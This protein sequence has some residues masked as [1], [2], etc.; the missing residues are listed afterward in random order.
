MA[1]TSEL[2][3]LIVRNI[4]DVEAALIRGRELGHSLI[5]EMGALIERERPDWSVALNLDDDVPLKF[6]P[7]SWL[8]R[9]ENSAN[10]QFHLNEFAGPGGDEEETWLSGLMNVGPA[11]VS[12][13]LYFWSDTF[14]KK[15]R[16]KQ[17]ALDRQSVISDLLERGFRQDSDQWLYL[18]LVLTPDDVALGFQTGDLDIALKPFGDIVS[19]IAAS[20]PELETIIERDELVS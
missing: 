13:A 15:K 6:G 9:G 12:I 5:E 19:T 17:L 18:P 8:N 3:A 10:C 16:W 20:V 4:G 14:N 7:R 2:D 1:D 11:G